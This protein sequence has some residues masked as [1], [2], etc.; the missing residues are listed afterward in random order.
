FWRSYD[1]IIVLGSDLIGDKVPLLLASLIDKGIELFERYQS[2]DH[3]IKIIFT[4]GK[5]NDELLSEGE[6]MAK[7]ALEK[8]LKKEDMIIENKAENTY[9]N[10][11]FSKRLIEE[12]ASSN[13]L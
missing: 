11:L 3:P 9:E 5:G 8:G 1:Y 7:Y 4:G 2:S 6:A 12:D 13:H 10:L